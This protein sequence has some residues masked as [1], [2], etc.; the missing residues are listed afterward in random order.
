VTLTQELHQAYSEY[1]HSLTFH[2]WHS[3]ATRE[4]IANLPNTAQLEASPTM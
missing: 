1:K 4:P 3:N 2:I